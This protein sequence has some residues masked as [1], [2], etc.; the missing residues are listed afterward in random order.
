MNL[1]IGEAEL[2]EDVGRGHDGQVV[3]GLRPESFEDASLIGDLAQERGI[4]FEAEIDLVE[5]LGSDLFAYFHVESEGVQSDQLADVIADRLEETGSP[6]S[7]RARSS[8][9]LALNQ[10]ARSKRRDTVKLW[11]DTAKTPPLRPRERREPGDVLWRQRQP[12]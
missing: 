10:P 7:A 2:S 11:A 4:V 1:P 5:S 8:W 6:N 12:G 9:S 3:A